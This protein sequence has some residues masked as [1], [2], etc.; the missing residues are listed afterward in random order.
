MVFLIALDNVS[1]GLDTL[2]RIMLINPD[3]IKMT[4]RLFQII[5]SNTYNQEVFKSIINVG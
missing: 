3:I 5:E 4:R 1:Y 2:N